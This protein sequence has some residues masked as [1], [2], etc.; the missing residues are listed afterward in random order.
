MKIN[1][2]VSVCLSSVQEIEVPDN[3]EYDPITLIP[4]VREQ[5]KLPQDILNEYSSD[6]WI[7][8]DMCVQ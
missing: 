6:D 4:Y 5:V 3:Y 1:V 7:V 8:D 2:D